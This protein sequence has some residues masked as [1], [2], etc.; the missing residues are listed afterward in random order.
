MPTT[1]VTN[2]LGQSIG[3]AVAD[4]SPRNR[5]ARQVHAGRTCRLEPLEVARHAAD[6]FA[7]NAQDKEGRNWTYMGYGPFSDFEA[8]RAWMTAAVAKDDPLFF[9]IIDL[10]S[11]KA[12]GVAALMRID[13]ANGV[14]EVGHIAYSP[15]LQRKA[16]ATEAMYLL[17]RH[18][19]DDLGYR[20]YEWKCDSLNEA[21]RHAA[22]RLGFTY[23]GLFRQATIYKGRNRDTAWFS[24]VDR[25]WP[26]I[27][28][29]F[30][31]WLTP[32]N[33]DDAGV[34]KT[35]LRDLI[36]QHRSVVR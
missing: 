13:P 10:E 30:E 32:E 19:F 25:E 9:A 16:A 1:N 26:G 11:G 15:L 23:E 28:V 5:P 36:I 35:Y 17:M 2:T 34:Q 33:F 4:W 24:I 14:I 29:A 7:A 8:Y 22:Y 20:R 12:V 18:V 6:L 3:W 21:S 27:K 31:E